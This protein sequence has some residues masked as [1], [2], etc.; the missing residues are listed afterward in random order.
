MKSAMWTW[1]TAITILA[2]LA[3]PNGVNA[4]DKQ[5]SSKPT[6]YYVFD[7]GAPLGGHSGA[8]GIND[9]GWI[10]GGSNLTGDATTHAELWI[11]VPFDLGTLGGPNSS[12]AWPVHSNN[13]Q[14]VGFSETADPD[15]LQEN[16]SCSAFFPSV[17]H[18]I[19][20][21]FLWQDG[22]MTGLPTLGGYN[23]YAAGVNNRSQAVGWA[24]NAVQDSTCVPPQVEQFEAVIWGPKTGQVTALP[25]LSGDLDG[26][27]TAINDKGQ[28]VGISGICD[29]AVGRFS[30]KHALLWQDGTPTD[31][32][33]FDGGVAW[34]TP[35]AINNR[36]VVVGFANLPD[37]QDGA[38]NPVGFIWSKEQPIQKLNPLSGDTNS[39]AYDIN[40]KGLV[41]GQSIGAA[42]SAVV[43]QN[44]EITD[45][46]T[47]IQANSSLSLLLANGVNAS[48]EIT[49]VAVDSSGQ[50]VGYL[51]VPVEGGDRSQEASTRAQATGSSRKPVLS[52]SARR[53][54]ARH[55]G[56][57]GTGAMTKLR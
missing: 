22:V 4:Q 16:W 38:F 42:S 11:G 12:I 50:L 54:L 6:M 40:E 31:L 19:C 35:A 7:L 8:V 47:L 20:L 9:V 17:T 29:V 49:G 56:L 41:V 23:G 3:L 32:G 37:D 43:W 26:A 2:A 21:G 53:Q 5:G 1:M 48:G 36:G 34:N 15:P 14:I 51:A 10:T 57:A 27:A 45:L 24:E 25:P 52:E 13:G 39:I 46:N 55:M 44:G 33:N 28:V 18:N 30:A